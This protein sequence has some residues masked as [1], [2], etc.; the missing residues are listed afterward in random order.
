MEAT[1]QD[2]QM[3]LASAD[4][5]IR[6]RASKNSGTC[7]AMVQPLKFDGSTSWTIFH[8]QFKTVADH[9]VWAAHEKA[10]QLF[11]I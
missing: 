7:V 5:Q 9:N 8:C 4:A 2:F 1:Y 6:C 11:T 10:V 3:Q